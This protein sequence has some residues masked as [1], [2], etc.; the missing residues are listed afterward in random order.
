ML[1]VIRAVLSNRY[2]TITIYSSLLINEQIIIIWKV[3]MNQVQERPCTFNVCVYTSLVHALLTLII[4]SARF[5]I[6]KVIATELVT[7]Y[8]W[9]NPDQ[10]KNILTL[11]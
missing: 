1:I 9:G 6:L 7:M 8:K 2:E 5:V 3:E 4:L 10:L 11:Y